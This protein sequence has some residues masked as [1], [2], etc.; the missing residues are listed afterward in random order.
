MI[1]FSYEQL[2]LDTDSFSRQEP[3]RN[4]QGRLAAN[5]T[6]FPNGINHITDQVHNL[7][8]KFG[9][10]STAGLWTCAKY[11]ASLGYEKI[12]AETFAGWGVCIVALVLD[13]IQTNNS[14]PGRLSQV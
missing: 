1:T 2:G 14:Q 13:F 6:R 10:Y 4:S 11:P 9:M 7:S 8:M 12:D 3:E 5:S